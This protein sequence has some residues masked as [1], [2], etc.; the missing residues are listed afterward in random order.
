MPAPITPMNTIAVNGL[1]PLSRLGPPL[2]G[3][4]EPGN[5]M[6][7]MG[8][9]SF[10]LVRMPNWQSITLYNSGVDWLSAIIDECHFG[11]CRRELL[12]ALAV[13]IAA[14]AVSLSP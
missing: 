9:P 5:A 6:S 10:N 13:L 7:L 11:F 1:K 2:A 4:I 14:S 3:S 8:K 12:T